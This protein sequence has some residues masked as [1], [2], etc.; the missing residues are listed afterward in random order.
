MTKSSKLYALI[1]S[2]SGLFSS[3]VFAQGLPGVPN[4]FGG[5]N[6][7]PTGMPN[8]DYIQMQNISSSP[9]PS[10]INHYICTYAPMTGGQKIQIVVNGFMCPMFIEYNIVTNKYR[11]PY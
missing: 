8:G 5:M 3:L 10:S 7:L 6:S 11:L 1:L 4:G 9:H 2:M